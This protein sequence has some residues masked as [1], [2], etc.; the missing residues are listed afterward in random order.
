MSASSEKQIRRLLNSFTSEYFEKELDALTDKQRTEGLIRFYIEKIHNPRSQHIDSEAIEEGLVDASND[1]GID[2]IHSDSGQVLIL[3]SKFHGKGKLG[4]T[5]DDIQN[6]QTC[7]KRLSDHRKWKGNSKLAEARSFLNF[8]ND[9]F[10]LIFLC[11]GRIDNQ[12]KTQ[13]Q[14]PDELDSIEGV[15]GLSSRTVIEYWDENRIDEE[16]R[17]TEKIGES[18]DITS[19]LYSAPSSGGKKR[20]PIVEIETS[21]GRSYIL[22]A[23]ANQLI[24]IYN[25][26]GVKDNLFSLNIRNYVGDTS[27]NKGIIKTAKDD[28]ERFFFFNN[29]ISCLAR[30]VNREKDAEITVEGL[31]VINGAQSVKALRKA[32]ESSESTQQPLI[33]V[34]ITE[35]TKG[36]GEEG[37]LR[38]DIIRYNNTQTTIKSVDFRS[39]DPVQNDL[40]AQFGKLKKDGKNVQ[41]INKRTDPSKDRNSKKIR[42]EE[43]AKVV[44][45]FLGD[46]TDF[47]H[48]TNFLFNVEK[49]GYPTVF[50]DGQDVYAREMPSD[51]FK[52]RACIWWISDA[53]EEQRKAD[54]KQLKETDNQTWNALERKWLLLHTAGR[55]L[56]KKLGDDEWK[57][58]LC[59][60]Y[61]GNWK[62]GKDSFGK[63]VENLYDVSKKIIKTQYGQDLTKNDFEHRGWFQSKTTRNG[64]NGLVENFGAE[65][66]NFQ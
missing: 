32:M 30:K 15:E 37:K 17:A 35:L 12:A 59:K 29:G 58:W 46:Y 27:S 38:E 18:T 21:I 66:L 57:A 63:D 44:Y 45:S 25:K 43:F 2:F 8:K 1:L 23:E 54:R 42:V 39:N 61:K 52:L 20:T 41:Y 13:S 47:A 34:R 11:M 5:R 22:I 14:E 62:F 7:L 65:L 4:A 48:N 10:V 55:L 51:E 60:G 36:Y 26:K 16:Y 6:F 3:Q 49:K 31:Q 40:H 33:L 24:N 53:F 64:L 28:P 19:T 9:N 50:G 56:L